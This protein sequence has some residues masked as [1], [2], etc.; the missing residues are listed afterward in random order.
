MAARA[1]ERP[2]AKVSEVFVSVRERDAAYDLLESDL[3]SPSKLAESC[4]QATAR[5]CVELPYV[6]VA[7]DG[8]SLR[9]ADHAREKDF[10]GI[11]TVK[12]GARGLKVINAL[13]I[14]PDGTT[15]GLLAQEYWAR[16]KPR[17]GSRSTRRKRRS[18]LPTEQKETRYWLQ[19]IE[20]A[21]EHLEAIGVR[22]WFQLDR[23]GDAWPIL[24]C[25][26]SSGHWF[27]VRSS[28]DRVVEAT[29]RDKQYLRAFLQRQQPVGSYELD[30][31]ARSNRPG[32]R[33]QM[34]MRCA[35]VSVRMRDRRSGKH[36][37]QTMHAVW[38]REEG[39][40]PAGEK[41]IDWLLLTNASVASLAD[42]REVVLGY[43]YRWRI[44][45]FHRTWKS[46]LCNVEQ[47]QLRSTNAVIRWATMLAAVA[48]RAERIKLLGRGSPDRPATDELS[49]DEIRVL[50]VLK[51]EQKKRTEIVPRGVPTMAQAMVW[52]ADLGGYTGKSS[53]GPPGAITIGRGL[54]RVVDGAN[55][56]RAL[57]EAGG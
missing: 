39:T 17:T 5:R 7:V 51:L 32:R 42:G 4:A 16:A 54:Q 47:T 25:L 11:G 3:V 55:A 57:R 28:W 6:L 27:T 52:L 10:G 43:G 26:A 20:H 29:G 40:V 36:R 22:G 18:K 24:D 45:E 49:D 46:G 38:V 44:E 48:A 23:E 12:A 9:L 13:A 53:G 50:I 14:G 21:Q 35:E 15:L 34:V 1:A 56:V 30:V 2:A 33:A 8:S 31:P 19:A 41:P 37:F